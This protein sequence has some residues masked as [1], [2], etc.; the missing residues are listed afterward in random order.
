[1]PRVPIRFVPTHRENDHRK[2]DR[3]SE[4]IYMTDWEFPYGSYDELANLSMQY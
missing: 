4:K 1:M 2:L 3:N